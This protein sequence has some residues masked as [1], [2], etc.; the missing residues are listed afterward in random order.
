VAL[1]LRNGR[2]RR[3]FPFRPARYRL[4]GVG[5]RSFAAPVDHRLALQRVSAKVSLMPIGWFFCSTSCGHLHANTARATEAPAPHGTLDEIFRTLEMLNKVGAFVL[6]TVPAA[7]NPWWRRLAHQVMRA[8]QALD[9]RPR[10]S[11]RSSSRSERPPLGD[12]IGPRLRPELSASPPR[13]EL[14]RGR[15]L[16]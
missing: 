10:R 4:G 2:R 6:L 3:A 14:T 15:G 5:H 11:P 12:T 8:F 9:R 13:I 7:K 1:T 16:I